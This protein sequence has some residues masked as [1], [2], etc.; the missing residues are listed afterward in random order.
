MLA[1]V[2]AGIRLGGIVAGAIHRGSVEDRMNSTGI[3]TLFN[4]AGAAVGP[5]LASFVLLPGLLRS[6]GS[7]GRNT[8]FYSNR[9]F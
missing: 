2:L 6:S 4:T 8:R 9:A 5:L 7:Y 3:A 1:V